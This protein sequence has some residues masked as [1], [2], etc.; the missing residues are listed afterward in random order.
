MSSLVIPAHAKVNLSLDV[1]GTRDDGYHHIRS[2]MAKLCLHDRVFLYPR[3]SGITL[4]C[5]APNLP[6]DH[7]NLAYQAATR[8]RQE[9]GVEAG[10]HLFIEKHI[11]I[12]AGLAGGSA[13]AAAVLWGL[14]QLWETGLTVTQLEKLGESIGSDVPFCLQGTCALVTGRGERVEELPW[15]PSGWVVLARPSGLEVAAAEAYAGLDRHAGGRGGDSTPGVMRALARGILDELASALGNGLEAPVAH[16][17]PQVREV[18]RA[19]LEAGAMG[20]C[21]SGSGPVVFGLVD[22]HTPAKLVAAAISRL[23]G[24]EVWVTRFLARARECSYAG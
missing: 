8:L 20:A 23:P 21:L 17:W 5:S 15:T 11:P 14:N 19:L 4:A 24:V 7:R 6:W 22:G 2:V 13:D 12:A 1:L 16:R 9:L 10:V 3:T 18:K